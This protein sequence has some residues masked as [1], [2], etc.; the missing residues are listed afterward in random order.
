MLKRAIMILFVLAV[1][2]GGAMVVAEGGN[3][4]PLCRAASRSGSSHAGPAKGP[5]LTPSSRAFAACWCSGGGE[6]NS[7]HV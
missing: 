6:W 1:A 3:G 5:A 4:T 7:C 2:G